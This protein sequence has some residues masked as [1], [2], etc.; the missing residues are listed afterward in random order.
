MCVGSVIESVGKSDT[1]E[2]VIHPV[3]NSL[4][5]C[6]RQRDQA[7]C[8]IGKHTY[9]SG[10]II[11]GS[12]YDTEIRS[13]YLVREVQFAQIHLRC[14]Q[15]GIVI[16]HRTVDDHAEGTL[17]QQGRIET[18]AQLQPVLEDIVFCLYGYRQVAQPYLRTVVAG[19]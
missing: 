17:Q 16:D 5:V 7:E 14:S 1:C 13:L 8:D 15:L 18:S 2:D 3:R 19:E 12:Y 4:E 9:L 10:E 6:T 11:V